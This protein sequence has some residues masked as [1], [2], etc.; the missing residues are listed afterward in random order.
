MNHQDHDNTL[1]FDVLF[2]DSIDIERQARALRARVLA[3]ATRN[4]WAW[5]VARLRRSP[6]GQTA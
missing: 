2:V 4:G 5:I 1:S 6:N 3:E